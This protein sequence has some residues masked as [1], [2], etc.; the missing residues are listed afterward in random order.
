M[1]CIMEYTNTPINNNLRDSLNVYPAK[2]NH[3]LNV[4][5]V[6]EAKD[7]SNQVASIYQK[8]RHMNKWILVVNPQAQSINQLQLD[9]NIDRSKILCVHSKKVNVELANLEK[10][11]SKGNCAAVVICDSLI[12]REDME[13]LENCAQAGK[14]RC[15]FLNKSKQLH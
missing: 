9:E 13:K 4:Q 7:M 6:G 3:W 2:K 14:T 12:D 10:T 15:I 1:D 11:L 5:Q 8:Y